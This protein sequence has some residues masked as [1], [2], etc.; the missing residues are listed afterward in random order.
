MIEYR[1]AL[2]EEREAYIAFADKVFTDNDGE[3]I[4]FDEA[5]PKVYGPGVDSAWMQHVAVDDEKGI[6]G[7]VA[8]MPNELYVGG[9]TLKTGYIGT[10]SVHAQARGEGHMKKL[11]RMCLDEM[12]SEDV[13]LALLNGQRQRYAYFGY[14]KSG[15]RWEVILDAR[16]IRHALKDVDAS[17][18]VFEKVEKNSSWLE[19]IR[20]LYEQRIVR[21]RR[22]AEAFVD[23]CRTYLNT[24]WVALDGGKFV[25]YVVSNDDKNEIP[26]MY[27]VTM[28]DFDRMLKGWF[29]LGCPSRV[30]LS[31][32]DWEV[33]LRRRLGN[34]AEEIKLGSCLLAR[35]LHPRKVLK[36]MLTVKAEYS[37]LADGEMEFEIEGDVFTVRVQDGKVEILDGAEHPHV[38]DEKAATQLFSYPFDYEGRIETPSGWFPLPLYAAAPDEF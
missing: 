34:Y 1:K 21:F 2:P 28:D 10:V 24:L 11:M 37:A 30:R 8:L 16:N 25:G 22:D 27:A 19:E 5:I 35:I 4:H 14:A 18:M 29:A 32:P 38:L 17:G 9:M 31:V 36:A 23:I 33:P 7:L 26:E 6:R 15:V 20:R 12:R 3:A 13:D